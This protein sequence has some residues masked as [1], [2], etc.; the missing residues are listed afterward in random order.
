MASRCSVAWVTPLVA[1]VV[2]AGAG[3]C[4]SFGAVDAASGPT[5]AV[6][7]ADSPD[8]ASGYCERQSIEPG[9]LCEDFDDAPPFQGWT[10]VGDAGSVSAVPFQDG[11]ALAASLAPGGTGSP[12]SALLTRSFATLPTSLAADLRID[13]V[14]SAS[15]ALVDVLVL[16]AF[17]K[18]SFKFRLRVRADASKVRLELVDAGGN[19]R[20][21]RDLAFGDRSKPARFRVELTNA[22]P[23]EVSAFVDD[24]R[25]LEGE[26]FAASAAEIVRAELELGAVRDHRPVAAPFTA[27]IDNVVVDL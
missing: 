10:F 6:A 8:A 15:G 25:V 7:S 26:R 19:V 18:D 12:V 1:L 13:P 23:L 14:V 3:S 9:R 5:D 27:T 2:V 21:S 24:Q 11:K 16:R 17:D 20:I 22:S 4:S